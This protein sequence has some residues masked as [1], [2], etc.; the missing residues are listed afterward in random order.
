M[1]ELVKN[2]RI[3]A[4]PVLLANLQAGLTVNEIAKL[5]GVSASGVYQAIRKHG[6]DVRALQ[7][8]KERRADLLAHTAMRIHENMSEDKIKSASLRDLATSLNIVHNA[9][10]LERGQS[11]SNVNM[12]ALMGNL[13]ELEEAEKRLEKELGI[14]PE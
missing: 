3:P 2:G 12:A 5:H 10:R 14:K 8:Y 9:E 7:V 6:I 4:M 13:K 1:N 11:T